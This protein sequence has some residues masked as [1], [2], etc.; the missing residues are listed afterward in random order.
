[1]LRVAILGVGGVGAMAAWQI[2]KAGH[3]V[4]AFEQFRLDHDQGSSYG[5]SRIVRRVYPDSL[6]TALMSESY[7]LWD[8]LMTEAHDS[9][10]FI[11]AGGIFCGDINHPD[12]VS[13]QTALKHSNVPFE[14]LGAKDCARRFP[15]F[16]LRSSEVAVYEPSMG[17]ARASKCVR[18]AAN[19]ARKH[20]ATIREETIVSEVEVVGNEKICLT[21]S[22]GEKV[23]ADRLVITMGGWVKNFLGKYGVFLP[24][25]VTRQYYAHLQPSVNA[26]GFEPGRFP[27]WIDA[28][29]NAYGF[30]HLGDIPGVK[31]GIHDHGVVSDPENVKRNFLAEDRENILQYSRQR[32]PWLSE[33][34]VYEKTCLYTNT[35]DENFIIDSIPNL[36]NSFVISSC[37]GH[38]F[39]FTPLM[40]QIALHLVTE[41][42]FSYDLSR[43]QIKSA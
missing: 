10:L 19:L 15:A 6:Y 22:T 28:Q 33:E 36:P 24:L 14:V 41:T 9:T 31:I 39:K 13:A 11:R 7:A 5:D 38:G 42:P 40:G 4:L 18:A 1:M 21:L 16:A 20:G 2:A 29:A 26:F 25:S 27:V 3:E 30:P 37:S 43:F 34:F 23:E 12:V 35:P 17:Y 32:F 8:S